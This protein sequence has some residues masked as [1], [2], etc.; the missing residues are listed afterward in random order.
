MGADEHRR[1]LPSHPRQRRRQPGAELSHRQHLGPDHLRAYTG[2]YTP[3]RISSARKPDLDEII[4]SRR[5]IV[6]W[7]GAETRRV[8]PEQ[9]SAAALGLLRLPLVLLRIGA[10]LAATG[11]KYH[12]SLTALV[13]SRCNSPIKS[14]DF[15]RC[16]SKSPG[17]ILCVR[18]PWATS[19]RVFRM[20]SRVR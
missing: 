3:V 4:A 5:R 8:V 10:Q 11:F 20:N 18:L 6:G 16:A 17:G 15:F 14:S 1:P 7:D 2:V 12:S 9:A 13:I 19:F